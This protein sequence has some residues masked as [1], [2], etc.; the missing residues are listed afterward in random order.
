M[1]FLLRWPT[2]LL[3]T[4]VLTFVLFKVFVWLL[5]SQY[6]NREI[7]SV[8]HPRDETTES[9]QDSLTRANEFRDNRIQTNK[10]AIKQA[11]AENKDLKVL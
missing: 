8:V 7:E 11:K 6:L 4:S 5:N 1:M 2:F 3:V 9:I 10:D